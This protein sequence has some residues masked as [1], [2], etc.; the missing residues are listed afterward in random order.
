MTDDKNDFERLTREVTLVSKELARLH[1]I[2]HERRYDDTA[3]QMELGNL[4]ER[5]ALAAIAAIDSEPLRAEV[6]R[7]IRETPLDSEDTPVEFSAP[8]VPSS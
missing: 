3:H 2:L 7:C 5:C 8:E 1:A 6:A 4:R